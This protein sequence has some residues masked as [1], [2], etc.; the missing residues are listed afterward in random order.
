M[1]NPLLTVRLHRGSP[2]EPGAHACEVLKD[3]GGM[4]ALFNDE[5]LIPALERIGIPTPD[6]RD[7]TNDGCWEVIIPGRTDFRFQR[8]SLMLC[9]EWALNR[10]RVAPRRRD[11]MAWTPATRAP[12]PPS[13]MSGRPS[14]PRWTPW[15]AARSQRV[16]ERIDD[17]STIAPVPLLSAL[18]DGAIPTRRDMTAGGARYRT[19]GML[20]ES[21]AYTIDSL[22]AI[23]TVVFE[24]RQATMA[25]LCDALDADLRGL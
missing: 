23:K 20:A 4:P 8:L 21:A 5:A 24:Q 13:T 3:G 17:R 10:G 11:R 22:A 14:L 15:S 25:E 12:S 19:Y 18:I 6:A 2:D 9:L 1:T 16:V 7:Y